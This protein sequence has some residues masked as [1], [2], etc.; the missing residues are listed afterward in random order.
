MTAV[1]LA[2]ARRNQIL[3]RSVL[4]SIHSGALVT[5]RLYQVYLPHPSFHR[6]NVWG[7]RFRP[8]QVNYQPT[9]PLLPQTQNSPNLAAGNQSLVT[10]LR[11][12][13][14]S[15]IRFC[16]Y[17][18]QIDEIRHLAQ[19]S[20][21]SPQDRIR[22]VCGGVSGS[23]RRFGDRHIAMPSRQVRP[24]FQVDQGLWR[25]GNRGWLG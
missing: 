6:K 11:F 21:S 15:F 14:L 4:L 9:P 3:S 16:R 5:L 7:A 12:Q 18:I 23:S 8:Y 25:R 17:Y 10:T 13:N 1:F 24:V 19:I 20:Q 2:D 22:L